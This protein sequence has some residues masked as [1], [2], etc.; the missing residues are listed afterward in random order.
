MAINSKSKLNAEELS[1]IVIQQQLKSDFDQK[2]FASERERQIES[3]KASQDIR[4][5]QILRNVFVVA[6]IVALIIAFIILVQRNRIKLE[7]NR[8]QSL[9]LNILPFETAKELKV[10]GPQHE[11]FE[12]TLPE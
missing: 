7:Q 11:R 2:T 9:L 3:I 5:E 6:F 10:Y 1:R 4:Q 8:S 12:D